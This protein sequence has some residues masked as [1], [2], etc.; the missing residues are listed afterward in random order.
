MWKRTPFFA[1][2][3]SPATSGAIAVIRGWVAMHHCVPPTYDPPIAP[4]I[5][6][7]QG[8]SVTQPTKSWLSSRS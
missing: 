5:P 7:Y 4:S 2:T 1:A 3:P 6:P 8:W